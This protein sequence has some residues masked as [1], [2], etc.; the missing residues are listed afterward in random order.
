MARVGGCDGAGDVGPVADNGDCIGGLCLN[1]NCFVAGTPVA[2]TDGSRPIEQIRVG[3]WVLARDEASGEVAPSRVTRTFVTRNMAVIDVRIREAPGGDIRATAGHRFWTVDRGWV[4][5]SEL[6]LGEALL[7]VRGRPPCHVDGMASEAAAETVFNFEVA[8]VHSYFVGAARVLVHNPTG[9]Q[10]CAGHPNPVYYYPSPEPPGG[11]GPDNLYR[12]DTRPPDDIFDAG[13]QPK[14]PGA[15]VG[16]HEYCS[17][18]TPSQ[19]ASTSTD[20]SASALFCQEEGYL[21]EI[22]PP[23]GGIDV[24]QTLGDASPFPRECEIAFPGGVPPEAIISA[25]KKQANGTFG[26]VI[27]NPAHGS[28]SSCAIQ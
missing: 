24:N 2:T 17:L 16:L 9:E 8:D 5:A 21:Y 13:F 1:G 3:D 23:S 4:E 15:T 26:P 27:K 18:N 7:D 25:Q 19:F 20:K 11:Y 14:R 6:T 12:G 28:G 10:P 22:D